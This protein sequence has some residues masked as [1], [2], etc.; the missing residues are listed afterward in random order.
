MKE[1]AERFRVLTA[2]HFSDNIMKEWAERFRVL[3]AKHFS[4]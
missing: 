4:D 1:W 2:K 3:T